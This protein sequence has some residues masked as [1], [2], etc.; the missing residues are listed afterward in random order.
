MMT[1]MINMM[2]FESKYKQGGINLFTYL[3]KINCSKNNHHVINE[4]RSIDILEY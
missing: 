2:I 4:I 3:Y 1:Y